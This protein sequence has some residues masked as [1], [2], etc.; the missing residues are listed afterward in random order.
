[1]GFGKT[2]GKTDWVE[3]QT[4][5]TGKNA[6]DIRTE[7]HTQIDG[8]VIAADNG[9]LKLD[10][11]TLGFSDIA[12]QD[13]E[14]GYYLNVGGTY[15][16]GSSE[17]KGNT[18][19]DSSQAG[20]GKEGKTGW[21][22]EGWNYEKEREQIVR[23]T[24]GAGEVVV[25]KDAETGGDSTAGL[26]RDVGKAYE[27]TKD[28]EK[29]TD[30]YASSSSIDAVLKPGETLK[31][32]SDGLLNYDK[33]ALDNFNKAAGA[34]HA[35]VNRVEV[36]QGRP[37]DARAEAMAGKDLAESTLEA[38]ILSGMSPRSAMAKMG[39]PEF[40]DSVLRSMASLNGIEPQVL[41]DAQKLVESST[42]KPDPQAV[43]LD[44]SEVNPTGIEELQGLIRQLG[45]IQAY[46]NKHPESVEAIAYVLAAAQ[47][48]KGVAQF[49]AMK[50]VEGTEAGQAIS[51]NIDK[52]NAFVGKKVAQIIE[53]TELNP[54]YDS[55]KY[56]IG[57]GELLSSILFGAMPARKGKG[58]KDSEANSPRPLAEPVYRTN[59]EAK[60]AAEALGYKKI[61]ETVHDGQAVF[62][63]GNLYITRDLDGHN[64]GAWKAAKSVK[65]LGS[66][67]TRL[68][69]FDVNMKRIGD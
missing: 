42:Y 1:V 16:A 63:Q 60:Q 47:G 68:G 34:L 19:Q 5:I 37:M 32:W 50:A 3:E 7:N 2:T 39:D 51:K 62:K 24:V 49:I 17:S 61:N 18:V 46:K 43:V 66:K 54:T 22:V 48:P 69:T 45:E 27:I 11:G 44:T 26:N 28:D 29:R 6:V 31:Q 65:A 13:K 57:G 55:D 25:P 23:A 35:L 38:L 59:K 56:L 40:I 15:K 20:K 12:G 67:D 64:G 53:G 14:H 10:T 4:R 9:N 36:M 58:G 33:T 41:S 30:L 21:S 52:A 8:A